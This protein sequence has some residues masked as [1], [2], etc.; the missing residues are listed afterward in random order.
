M[1]QQRLAGIG[2]V[3]SMQHQASEQLDEYALHNS[4][5]PCLKPSARVA[6]LLQAA[7]ISD[8][9]S[10]PKAATLQI[11]SHPKSAWSQTILSRTSATLGKTSMEVMLHR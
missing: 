3:K 4:T 7:A 6:Q 5:L 11:L 1:L 8:Q 2:S 9:A 10:P